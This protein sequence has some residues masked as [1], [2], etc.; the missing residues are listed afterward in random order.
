MTAAFA[1]KHSMTNVGGSCAVVAK[2]TTD[3][4]L[5]F[6]RDRNISELSTQ[7]SCKVPS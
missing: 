7:D 3:D 2:R 6:E 1:D 5:H 4:L